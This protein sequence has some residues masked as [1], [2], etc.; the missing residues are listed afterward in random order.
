[1]EQRPPTGPA[2]LTSTS[3]QLS[4]RSATRL[5]SPW[6][7]HRACVI[8]FIRGK[9]GRCLHRKRPN[10]SR[11]GSYYLRKPHASRTPPTRIQCLNEGT[12]MRVRFTDQNC[13]EK[14]YLDTRPGR[15]LRVTCF[16]HSM[17]N[18]NADIRQNAA[19]FYELAA[20]DSLI[21][22]H[23]TKSEHVQLG[24]LATSPDSL[25]YATEGMKHAYLEDLCQG[26]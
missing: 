17:S 14:R 10:L 1:M 24:V 22:F 21:F 7:V 23:T 20:R 26:E 6:L 18:P 19:C 15:V 8:S 25:P 16:V 13:G 4:D 11:G 2:R 3:D 12:E 9:G 5:V